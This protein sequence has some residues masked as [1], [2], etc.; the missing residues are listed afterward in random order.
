M[1]RKDRSRAIKGKQN[2][3]NNNKMIKNK[4]VKKFA[5]GWLSKLI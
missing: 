1:K 5:L 4:D 2:N 3:N